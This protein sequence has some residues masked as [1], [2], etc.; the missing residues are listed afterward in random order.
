MALPERPGGL[1]Q[2]PVR[3]PHLRPSLSGPLH[4]SRGY[5]Q[6]SAGLVY[7]RKGHLS[8]AGLGS[9]QGFVR[10]RSF[11]FLANRRRASLLPRCF[12]LLS[13]PRP[14]SADPNPSASNDLW[15]CPKCG[16]PMTVLQRLTP[17]EIQLRAHPRSKPH[18][19]SHS[20]T[21]SATDSACSVPLRLAA[22]QICFLRTLRDISVMRFLPQPAPTIICRLLSQALGQLP[23]RSLSYSIPITPPRPPQPRAA[24]FKRVYR[25]R[26]ERLA[27]APAPPKRASDKPLALLVRLVQ[28]ASMAGQESLDSRRLLVSICGQPI[29]GWH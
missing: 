6:P 5:L 29:Y 12:H 14:S 8:L 10:I 21:N 9:P 20:Y 4:P 7:G 25:T 22:E 28:Q 24:S 11:G 13:A 26:A 15:R 18:E 17:A 19:T 27:R 1:R 3:R 16:G 23:P 2:T